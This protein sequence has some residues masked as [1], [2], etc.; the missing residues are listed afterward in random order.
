MDTPKASAS[1]SSSAAAFAIKDVGLRHEA[2]MSAE[3]TDDCGAE[4]VGQRDAFRMYF[5]TI[6]VFWEVHCDEVKNLWSQKTMDVDVATAIAQQLEKRM[7]EL[8]QKLRP[9]IEEAF[10]QHDVN[11]DGLLDRE[12][13]HTFLTAYGH[14]QVSTCEY[15]VEYG[16]ELA[17]IR[18]KPARG[19]D[20]EHLLLVRE[21]M[22][23]ALQ[24]Q[25]A[26]YLERAREHHMR[27]ARLLDS[28][29][30]LQIAKEKLVRALLPGTQQNKRFVQRLPTLLSH[31]F[32]P[33]WSALELRPQGKTL[34]AIANTIT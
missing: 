27:A 15:I 12:E 18:R 24:E 16:A 9:I 32:L 23:A 20:P 7:V 31:G 1:E 19:V 29:T 26:S 22:V 3:D 17:Q 8:H 2:A 5:G 21:A 28:G 13:I 10:A 11:K 4:L 33:A 14:W 30:N 25:Y 6:R 34:A